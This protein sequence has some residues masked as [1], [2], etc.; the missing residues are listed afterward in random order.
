MSSL[1]A[2]ALEWF[3]RCMEQDEAARE[4]AL[5]SLQRSDPELHIEVTRLLAADA[6][7]GPLSQS[8]QAILGAVA[9]P[10]GLAAPDARIGTTLGAWRIDGIIGVGGMGRVYRASRADGQYAQS[11]ALK[12]V[13]TEVDSPVL[14]QAIRNERGMLAMLEH[15][16][17]A[18]L[19]DGG[20]DADGRPWFAMQWVQGEPIDRW[21]DRRRLDVRA[22]VELFIQLCDAIAYAHG[23]GALHSD[24]KPSNVL[25]D[26]SGRL[27]LLDFGLSSLVTLAGHRRIA[28]TL[29]YTA[30]EVARHGCS[31]RSD[32]YA[33]GAVL[34]ELLCGVWPLQGQGIGCAMPSPLPMSRL[35]LAGSRSTANARGAATPAALAALLAGD[36]ERIAASCVCVDPASRPSS[37]AQLREDLRAWLTSRP[38]ASRR[39]ESGY[40]LRL[41]LRRHRSAAIVAVIALTCLGAG[42]G[43]GLHLRAQAADNAQ[44]A[45]AMKRLFEESFGALTTGSLGQSR[46]MAPSMLREA[47]AKLRRGNSDD[48]HVVA[49]RGLMLM[50]LA[51]SYTVLGDYRHAM[52]L[53]MEAEVV[54]RGHVEQAAA[55]NVSLAH[56]L[57]LQSRYA[58]ALAAVDDGQRELAAV[59]PPDR[60]F[61]R[62]MLQV[63]RAR[64]EWGMARINDAMATLRLAMTQAEAMASRDPTP[65]AALLL[66]RGQWSRLF[67]RFEEAT[68]DFER[69]AALTAQRA[70]IVADEA[71][72]ELVRTLNQ[73]GLH[74]RAVD[75][76]QELLKRRR[77]MLGEEHPE[78]GKAWALLGD[79]QFWSGRIEDA[80]HSAR[81]GEE[82]LNAA[83]GADHPE[84][85]LASIV[86]GSI[87]AQTGQPD[88]AVARAR[89]TLAIM[90]KAHGP[91]HQATLKAVGHLAAT[92]AVRASSTPQDTAPWQEVISLYARKVDAGRR[93]GLPM[94]SERAML[95]K[96]KLRVGRIDPGTEQ[97]LDAVIQSLAEARG[98]ASDA[99][100]KLRFT[101][102]EVYLAQ[103]KTE[104]ASAELEAMLEEL[105]RSPIT[106]AAEGDRFNCLERL[107]DIALAQGRPGVAREHWEQ[108]RSIGRRIAPGQVST[109]R[110]EGKLAELPADGARV[111]D[112][113]RSGEGQ[114]AI[115]R[116]P[117]SPKRSSK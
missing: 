88:E 83:L 42:L 105:A 90:E 72:A 69:A 21:C 4:Q 77:R 57:N 107:G 89:R 109:R 31:E 27:V 5:A 93:Q 22:R 46:L 112:A 75:L 33:M 35:A 30:P 64:A 66:Q 25:V 52:A 111:Q 63:E 59:P 79:A 84:T 94:L 113:T 110:I 32:I 1:Q 86:I 45:H 117:P 60:E 49:T 100:R 9:R 43:I 58:D 36:L 34:H 91:D 116:S 40:R 101:R 103:E 14:A 23:K 87:Q 37:V 11:V 95:I 12:C 96:A 115:L 78:T 38:L 99:V 65:L 74:A 29:G 10:A 104:R 106:L 3:S 15:P 51:R 71:T 92:L 7:V 114:I 55:M 82:V 68:Q 28:M 48:Q 47:E 102:I 108:A 80:L 41:F 76:A 2:Q 85:A 6:L 24:I 53:V 8:P 19:L 61:T 26:E 56:L 67:S 62:L 17:L 70:P 39:H 16:N 97:E 50:A 20:I 18:T 81:R 13:G 54:G 73:L 98:K 44:A